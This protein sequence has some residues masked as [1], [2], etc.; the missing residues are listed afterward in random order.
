MYVHVYIV[1]Y[2]STH[3]YISSNQFFLHFPLL[4]AEG[5]TISFTVKEPVQHRTDATSQQVG[6]ASRKLVKFYTKGQ[7]TLLDLSMVSFCD[8]TESC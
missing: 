5:S 2:T 6:F 7:G 4:N 3:I 8:V 1:F